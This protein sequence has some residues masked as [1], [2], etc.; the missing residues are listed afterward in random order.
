M[1]ILVFVVVIMAFLL[2]VWDAT[3]HAIGLTL[4]EGGLCRD[5]MPLDLPWLLWPCFDNRTTYDTF[6]M[7]VHLFAAGGIILAYRSKSHG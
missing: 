4:F 6:W 2:M 1:R 7:I 5:G 3:L